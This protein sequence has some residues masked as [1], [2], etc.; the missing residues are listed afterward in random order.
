VRKAFNT[1]HGARVNPSRR[2]I[3]AAALTLFVSLQLSACGMTGGSLKS[4]DTD[5]AL[6][7]SSVTPQTLPDPDK[8]SDQA[9]IRNAVSSANLDASGGKALSWANQDTG[10]RGAVSQIAEVR[11]DG[12]LCRSFQTSRESFDGIALYAGKT[13]LE[14][15]GEW[16]LLSF[17]SL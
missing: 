2:L 17:D 3:D 1:K 12:R 11:Q 7:T 14:E 10:S 9:T 16:S 4:A 13:C 6:V 8:L 5:A 15:N